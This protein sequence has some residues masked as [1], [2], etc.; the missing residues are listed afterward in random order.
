MHDRKNLNFEQGE[1]SDHQFKV[2][3]HG[4]SNGDSLDT[5]AL[6]RCL[7]PETDQEGTIWGQ[8]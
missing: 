8:K 6:K 3:I 7:D 5:R 2:K 1:K 4:E